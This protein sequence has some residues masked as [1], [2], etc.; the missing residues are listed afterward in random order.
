MPETKLTVAQVLIGILYYLPREKCGFRRDNERVFN[1]FSDRQ[2][3][4]IIRECSDSGSV[5]NAI[6]YLL[7]N[8][9]LHT[10]EKLGDF[11]CFMVIEDS[12]RG[13]FDE[14]KL[15]EAQKKEL[16]RLAGE[17]KTEV[18]INTPHH[19]STF[20]DCQRN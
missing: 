7:I 5:N 20:H 3:L 9:Y 18:C 13:A 1:F 8:K 6:S 4:P 17:F 19:Y 16:E 12:V 11:M 15:S 2:D 14:I 10:D